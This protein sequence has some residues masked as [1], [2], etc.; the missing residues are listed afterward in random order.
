MLQLEDAALAQQEADA[1]RFI[2]KPAK[3]T[4]S[5]RISRRRPPELTARQKPR[6]HSASHTQSLRI[7]CHSNWPPE[8][9]ERQQPRRRSASPKKHAV[10]G[11]GQL[12]RTLACTG[13]PTRPEDQSC[14][15]MPHNKKTQLFD[16][17]VSQASSIA[18]ILVQLEWESLEEH[19][20]FAP[21]RVPSAAKATV[22]SSSS[23]LVVKPLRLIR[24]ATR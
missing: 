7:S 12:V 10:P 23:S 19:D 11:S 5:L 16:G 9:C 1:G 22:S 24:R 3:H 13:L 2:S 18:S 17:D 14:S 15:I 20:Q 4:Q 21:A 8:L 6:H